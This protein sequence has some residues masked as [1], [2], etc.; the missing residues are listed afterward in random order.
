MND[1]N[2]K[3]WENLQDE[4][5]LNFRLCELHLTI[6][7]TELE[8][9]VQQLYQELTQKNIVFHPACYLADEWLCPD[10]EPVIGIPF[11]LAHCFSICP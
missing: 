4:E 2:I 3:N 1:K 10:R 9:Y 11:Y 6:K 5:L 8:I 7:G